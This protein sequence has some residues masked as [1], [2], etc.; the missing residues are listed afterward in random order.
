MNR[1]EIINKTAT[2]LS[3]DEQKVAEYF[4]SIFETISAVLTKGKSINIGEFGKFRV[5]VKNLP[6]G[7][8][9]NKI[10]FS[11]SKKFADDANYNFNELI[12]VNVKMID[13]KSA[14]GNLI[15]VE[16]GV[17]FETREE[18][19]WIAPETDETHKSEEQEI[20]DAGFGEKLEKV[21]TIDEIVS[22]AQEEDHSIKSQNVFDTVDFPLEEEQLDSVIHLSKRP[23]NIFSDL[24]IPV[25]TVPDYPK[26]ISEQ[27]IREP[28]EI[29]EEPADNIPETKKSE[30]VL[31]EKPEEPVLR[32]NI[33]EK[34]V[35][36]EETLDKGIEPE[37]EDLLRRML[38]QKA[39]LIPKTKS[40]ESEE[41]KP[42]IFD[43]PLKEATESTGATELKVTETQKPEIIN[44]LPLIKPVHIPDNPELKIFG[45]LSEENST[46]EVQ[47]SLPPPK[48]IKDSAPE[49]LS[50]AGSSTGL[51]EL[52][53]LLS[54]MKSNANLQ[55]QPELKTPVIHH[56]PEIAKKTEEI[57]SD[58]SSAYISTSHMSELENLLNNMATGKETKLSEKIQI[59][60][61]ES[62]E[63]TPHS[64]DDIFNPIELI[65]TEQKLEKELPPP[66]PIV[67]KN[68][69]PPKRK[70]I[71]PVLIIFMWIIG[72]VAAVFVAGY[73]LNLDN[74]S[75][76]DLSV[77]INTL[78]NL[79]AGI[80][81][82]L[83]DR[84]RQEDEK[85]RNIVYR[86][87]QKKINIREEKDG[88]YIHYGAY[89]KRDSTDKVLRF[90]RE[91]KLNPY[92]EVLYGYIFRVVIGPYNSRESAM[93]V[94]QDL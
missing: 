41:I 25:D 71:S 59:P 18:I 17:E 90:L 58:L 70:P 47:P 30:P 55:N 68:V 33:E 49:I 1:E 22:G 35:L 7:T 28:E 2:D 63:P 48:I 81:K 77:E 32:Q 75:L 37:K 82:D 74:Q 45:K 20:I 57:K 65:P 6:D 76:D 31:N 94:I 10:V 16:S 27:G 56:P 67:I 8:K 34:P 62:T 38:E 60:D 89:A 87:D 39:V 42:E 53:S 21:S 23:Q 50:S 4:D 66:P 86:D 83:T 88:F 19:L 93:Q 14:K 69:P 11:P 85:D 5:Q 24:S 54:K 15:P 29:K 3:L 43:V 61:K 79:S 84:L 51:N 52:E 80:D 44:E 92:A 91:R 26:I 13:G 73:L 72:V 46:D 64:Y 40:L 36:R 9:Q 12:P 78:K